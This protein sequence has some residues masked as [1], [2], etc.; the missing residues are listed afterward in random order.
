MNFH[1]LLEIVFYVCLALFFFGLFLIPSPYLEYII[2]GCA[3]IKAI[4]HVSTI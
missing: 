4:L 2:G 1:N 3:A